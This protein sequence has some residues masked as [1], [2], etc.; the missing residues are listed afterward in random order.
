MRRIHPEILTAEQLELLP[1][2]KSFSKDF[3]LVGGTAI[4]I[5]IGHRR[6]IDFD[7][8]TDKEFDNWKIRR[9]ILQFKKIDSVLRDE[10]GQYTV[11]IHKVRFT[12]F[13]YPFKISFSSNFDKVI[14]LPDL[15]TLAAM[16][17]Y[18]LGRRAK[19]KDY[20]DLYFVMKD[21]YDISK[22]IKKARLI[23]GA[24]F[25]EKL[26]RAQLS[27][28][29]DIDYSEKVDFMEGFE[30][31]DEIIKRRLIDFSLA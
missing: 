19:W 17:A 14:G 31:A 30:I 9:K 23:Y 13:C 22:V 5:F 18:A 24:E 11:V 28:F 16:K 2:V 26:F 21:Y 1:L 20:V 8:F 27:Y 12:F 4:A 15:L 29:K 10:D 7:L 25:N 3:G 6:S